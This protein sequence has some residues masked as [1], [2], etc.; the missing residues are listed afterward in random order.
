[1]VSSTTNENKNKATFVDSLRAEQ[2]FY[3]YFKD[4]DGISIRLID[5]VTIPPTSAPTT[6]EYYMSSVHSL[7]SIEGASSGKRNSTPSRNIYLAAALGIAVL[8]CMLTVVSLSHVRKAR[9]KMMNES[10]LRA[11]RNDDKMARHGQD[12][13]LTHED[14]DYYR[15]VESGKFF[16][17]LYLRR[18]GRCYCK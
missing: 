12:G 3:S 1:M 11:K 18:E 14:G 17:W 2:L 16:F 5:R 10:I 6:L 15:H 9:N 13:S 8:W 4:V 7:N